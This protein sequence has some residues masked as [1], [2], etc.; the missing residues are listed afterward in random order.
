[1]CHTEVWIGSA[2]KTKTQIIKNL[3]HI[4][5]L[6]G[7]WVSINMFI[8]LLF[9]LHH[10]CKSAKSLQLHLILCYPMDYSLPGSS[11]HG[12]L[13]ARIQER[14]AMPSSRG[15]SQP[16]NQTQVFCS[17]SRFFT[18]EPPRELK[19]ESWN[20]DILYIDL[21][22]LYISIWFTVL[23]YFD[24]LMQRTDTLEKTLMLGKIEGGRRDDRYWDGWIASL[25]P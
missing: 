23:Q 4:Y 13:Q 10:T 12:I 5:I 21:L 19:A 24:H 25:T 3:K 1:M 16:R 15:S 11:V 17:A 18:A 9:S 2:F 8:K 14:V 6:T 20:I 22:Y 7:I